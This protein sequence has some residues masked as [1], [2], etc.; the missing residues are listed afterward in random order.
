M[1]TVTFTS[2]CWF[3]PITVSRTFRNICSRHIIKATITVIHNSAANRYAAIPHLSSMW[4]QRW[5]S[6][7]HH[8]EEKYQGQN[9][10]SPLINQKS[11]KEDHSAFQ[12]LQCY[13]FIIFSV[14]Y[15]GLMFLGSH[16]KRLLNMELP[17]QWWK[18]KIDRGR[19][20][21]TYEWN[22]TPQSVFST[23]WYV[24]STHF[25]ISLLTFIKHVSANT[26][27]SIPQHLWIRDNRRL[28]TYY[29]WKKTIM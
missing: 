12:V 1:K 21:F 19:Y 28:A 14:I 13:T 4:Q 22:F 10:S 2:H 20:T 6:T 8:W 7:S 18:N 24:A 26:S 11:S 17:P 29:F 9:I 5:I 27:V 23:N 3:C 16:S 15:D 25:V